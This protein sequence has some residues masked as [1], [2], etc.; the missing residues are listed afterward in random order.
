MP[1]LC[2]LLE[3]RDPAAT[4][5]Q[6]VF[7]PDP[8]LVGREH[9]IRAAGDSLAARLTSLVPLAPVDTPFTPRDL[10]GSPLPAASGTLPPN[11]LRVY[12]GGGAP[13]GTL[14]VGAVGGYTAQTALPR[15]WGGVIRFDTSRPWDDEYSLFSVALHEASHAFGVDEHNPKPGSLLDEFA[16]PVG[17]IRDVDYTDLPLFE[18]AGFTV[19]PITPFTSYYDYVLVLGV[20]VQD[21]DGVPDGMAFM[22]PEDAARAYPTYVPGPAPPGTSF[23][24]RPPL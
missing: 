10:D 16:P 1:I 19:K 12:V 21:G 7:E 24:L 2:E 15:T 17:V 18:R 9:V 5:L 20:G 22:T 6:W 14:A 23:A 11:T 3:S 8:W 13:A 4:L